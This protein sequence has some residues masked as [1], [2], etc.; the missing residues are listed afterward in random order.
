MPNSRRGRLILGGVLLLF[1]AL[2]FSAAL[3]ESPTYDESTHLSSGRIYWET[4]RYRRDVLHT[5]LIRLWA[6]LPLY[7]RDLAISGRSTSKDPLT[8]A[9]MNA[10]RFMIVVLSAL[11][12]FILWRW[13]F[14]ALGAEAAWVS[15]AAFVFCPAMLEFSH[16][17]TTDMGMAFFSTLALYA[18]WGY[19]RAPSRSAA[20]AAGLA[21]GAALMAKLSAALLLPLCLGLAAFETDRA[22]FRGKGAWKK[23]SQPLA[24][25][26]LC[27]AFVVL[28]CYRVVELPR[29]LVGMQGIRDDLRVAVPHYFH[30]AYNDQGGWLWFL[31][32]TFLLKTPLPF[33]LLTGAGLGLLAARRYEKGRFAALWLLLPAALVLAV[34]SVASNQFGIRRIL[35][36]YPPLCLF[37]GG[38]WT[39]LRKISRSWIWPGG[40]LALW[41][42]GSTLFLFPRYLS[43]FNESVGGPSQ[44]YRYLLDCNLDWGQGLK[45]LGRYLEEQ[46]VHQIYLCYFGAY[47]PHAYGINYLPIA[48]EEP[49]ASVADGPEEIRKEKKV[50]FVVSAT[51]LEGLYYKDHRT[52]DWLKTRSPAAVLMDSLWVYDVTEDAD[53]LERLAD[54]YHGKGSR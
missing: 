23:Y 41:Y 12:G 25:Y 22:A 8:V 35:F 2:S 9:E 39:S 3:R 40:A 24:V 14:D 18:A 52:F 44:G 54:L 45:S 19:A 6:A 50:L 49:G 51:N 15:L 1:G 33:L 48:P 20:A 13:A 53:A 32:M 30:G 4:G 26:I 7:A 11:L 10:G 34:S 38:A 5:P 17:V 47:D 42:A 31:P 29:L 43:Y 16:L 28:L 37:I 21:M 46:D 36:L 27:A